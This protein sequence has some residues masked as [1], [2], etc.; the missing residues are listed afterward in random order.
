[1]VEIQTLADVKE[2]MLLLG[3]LL[4]Y[5]DLLI[6]QAEQNPEI[7]DKPRLAEFSRRR[8][9]FQEEFDNLRREVEMLEKW[10]KL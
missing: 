6:Q 3:Q 9:E 7:K 10:E 5:V 8:A 4:Q 2:T 1:M